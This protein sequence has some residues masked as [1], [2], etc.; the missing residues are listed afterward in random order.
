MTAN[1]T[2]QSTEKRDFLPLRPHRLIS[3]WEMIQFILQEYALRWERILDASQKFGLAASEPNGHEHLKPEEFRFLAKVESDLQSIC[4]WIQPETANVLVVEFGHIIA[5]KPCSYQTINALLEGILNAIR[6]DTGD[7][8]FTFIPKEKV[9]YFDKGKGEPFYGDKPLFGEKVY[10]TFPM[11]RV[12]IRS[13]GSCLALDLF[14]AAVFHLCRTA[15]IG[16]RALAK[17]LKVKLKYT[18]EYA[19]WGIVIEKVENNLAKLKPHVR[20]RKKSQKLEFYSNMA[21][22]C[23][24]IKE[25][26]RDCIMHTRKSFNEYGAMDAYTRVSGFMRRMAD[27][28]Q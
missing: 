2:G 28:I 12:E 19:D 6:R 24:A 20:G 18:I 3:L 17:Q 21:S 8:R 23:R 9:P 26:W 7:V 4:S 10:D 14:D 22:D 1:E 13:A 5:R 15:E 11:A 16:L 25:T 27:S